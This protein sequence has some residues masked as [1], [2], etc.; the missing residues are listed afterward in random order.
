MS[1]MLNGV[2]IQVV[3]PVNIEDLVLEA[4][5]RVEGGG[6]RLA[7]T[8]DTVR[9]LKLSI[10]TDILTTVEK[11]LVEAEL[12]KVTPASVSADYLGSGVACYLRPQVLQPGPLDDQWTWYFEMEEIG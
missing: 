6:L 8:G 4:S 10:K 12:L 1:I 3:A 2:A 9:A 5:Q 11:D 7:R